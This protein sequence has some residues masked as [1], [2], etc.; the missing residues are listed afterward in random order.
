MLKT[1][2]G[3]L[4]ILAVYSPV[5]FLLHLW[6]FIHPAISAQFLMCLYCFFHF[7]Y[8]I[9]DSFRAWP[10]HYAI[11]CVTTLLHLTRL[12]NQ[13]FFATTQSCSIP[14]SSKTKPSVHI[15]NRTHFAPEFKFY[16]IKRRV[17]RVKYLSWFHPLLAE[18]CN[19]AT[20]CLT[21]QPLSQ[22]VIFGHPFW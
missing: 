21:L 22:V 13:I 9:L 17:C 4:C 6:S 19:T 5:L 3:P 7:P 11:P 1:W 15:I 18:E 20:E 12:L 2:N 10:V 8:S 16:R 14:D